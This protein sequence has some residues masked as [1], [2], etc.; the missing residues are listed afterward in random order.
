M[1][2]LRD[3]LARTEQRAAATMPIDFRQPV[4]QSEQYKWINEAMKPVMK[5]MGYVSYAQFKRA[6]EDTGGNP[7][8]PRKT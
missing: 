6:W 3:D 2:F 8:W 1:Q 7:P 4:R 5:P